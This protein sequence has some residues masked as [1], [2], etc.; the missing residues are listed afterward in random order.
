MIVK[1]V[2]PSSPGGAL[3]FSEYGKANSVTPPPDSQTVD[4]AKLEGNHH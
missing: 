3:T 2:D 4:F 1:I